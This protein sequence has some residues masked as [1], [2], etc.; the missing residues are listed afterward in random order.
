MIHNSRDEETPPHTRAPEA[1]HN[2]LCLVGGGGGRFD[3]SCPAHTLH[4]QRLMLSHQLSMTTQPHTHAHPQSHATHQHHTHRDDVFI[5]RSQQAPDFACCC[6]NCT[7]VVVFVRND[8][9]THTLL[10][11]RVYSSFRKP[12]SH[13]KCVMQASCGVHTA[14][15]THTHIHTRSVGFAVLWSVRKDGKMTNTP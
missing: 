8:S 5:T 6:C 1:R 12:R 15:A 10:G 7:T 4:A 14:I 2:H 11:G 13:R 9:H 3:A